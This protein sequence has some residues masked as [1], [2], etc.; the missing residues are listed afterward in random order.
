MNV[1]PFRP[2]PRRRFPRPVEPP[3]ALGEDKRDAMGAHP[4]DAAEDR[5]RMQQ[6]VAVLAVVA[7]LLVL[8]VWIIDGLQRYTRTLAC[9]EA[10][11][12]H[13]TVLDVNNL[14]GGR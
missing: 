14:P 2:A 5:L 3:P 1:I 10:A 7:V 11:H 6:N 4:A 12:R 8:G 9:I 13:C